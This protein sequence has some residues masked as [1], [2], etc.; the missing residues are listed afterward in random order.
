MATCLFHRLLNGGC[1]VLRLPCFV[2]VHESGTCVWLLIRYCLDVVRH[3]N[4]LL[5]CIWN[6]RPCLSSIISFRTSLLVKLKSGHI[7]SVYQYKSWM[8]LLFLLIPLLSATIVRIKKILA[9]SCFFYSSSSYFI[10]TTSISQS[11]VPEKAKGCV[12]FNFSYL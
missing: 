10:S 2:Y 1:C 8:L 12:I 9:H 7:N 6:R 3:T 5:W 11:F 4:T